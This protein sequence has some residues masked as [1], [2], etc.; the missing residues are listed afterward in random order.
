MRTAKAWYCERP[1][2]ATGEGTGSGALEGPGLMGG[3]EKLRL[4]TMERAQERLRIKVQPSG[5]RGAQHLEMPV[6]WDDQEQ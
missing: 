3:V 5:N 6:P 2:E 4:D 1:E